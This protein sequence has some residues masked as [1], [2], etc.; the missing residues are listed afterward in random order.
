MAPAPVRAA[1]LYRP[2]VTG[3][4]RET[5]AATAEMVKLAEN[6]YRD[7]NIALA[8]NLANLSESV[9]VNVW[10]VLEEI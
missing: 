9:G 1:H 10:N 4:L 2:F 8:N 7:V 5:D 6:T 3:E